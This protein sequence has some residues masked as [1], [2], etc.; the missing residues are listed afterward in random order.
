MG[1]TCVTCV[2][3][4]VVFKSFFYSSYSELFTFANRTMYID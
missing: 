4:Q 1:S 3:I 2:A